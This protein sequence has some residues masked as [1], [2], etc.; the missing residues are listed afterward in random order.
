M[1]TVPKLSHVRFA[2]ADYS[3]AQPT[4]IHLD[5]SPDI[6]PETPDSRLPASAPARHPA[7][8]LPAGKGFLQIFG[9]APGPFT[10]AWRE[11]AGGSRRRATRS[12]WKKAKAFADQKAIDLANLQTGLRT[13]SPVDAASYLRALEILAP[14]GKPIELVAAEY[15]Q[16]HAILHTSN[17]SPNSHTLAEAARFLMEHR[18]ADV[19]PKTIPELVALLLARQKKIGNGAKGLR[20]LA[21][22][23]GVFAQKF[24][25]PLHVLR[26]PDLNAWEHSLSVGLRTRKNYRAAVSQIVRFAQDNS[27]LSKTWDELSHLDKIKPLPTEAL[28]FTPDKMTRLIQHCPGNLVPLVV[29]MAFGGVR[30]EEIS[31]EDRTDALLDWSNIDLAKGLIRVPKTVA[32]TKRMRLIKMQPNLIAWLRPHARRSGPICDLKC[33][34]DALYRLGKRAG[35]SWVKNACRNSFISYRVAASNDVALVA[36]EAGNSARIIADEYLE[37]VTQEQG[38]AWFDIFPRAEEDILHLPLFGWATSRSTKL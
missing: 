11:T 25:G 7:K 37:L 13:L 15:A 26:A 24:P 12:T 9:R 2:I 20:T 31:P 27:H 3:L 35:V 8:L 33:T 36:R 23:L 30:H 34:G 21:Q 5:S 16:A 19:T 18:P 29:L 4:T 32:K 38:K 14:S 28:L 1:N 10:I 22:Q 17:T 6:R